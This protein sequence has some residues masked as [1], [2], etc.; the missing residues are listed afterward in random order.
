MRFMLWANSVTRA[1]VV[2]K[3]K[4]F[5]PYIPLSNLPVTGSTKIKQ[6]RPYCPCFEQ[7]VCGN[8]WSNVCGN[9]RRRSVLTSSMTSGMKWSDVSLCSYSGRVSVVI[10]SSSQGA[11]SSIVLVSDRRRYQI[12]LSTNSICEPYA[13]LLL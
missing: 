7:N 3:W 6:P 12:N 10:S 9:G 11:Q 1:A 13:N 2:Q 5:L 4:D 8:V